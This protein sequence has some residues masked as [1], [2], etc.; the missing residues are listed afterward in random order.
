MLQVLPEVVRAIKLLGLITLAKLVLGSQ[1]VNAC[2]PE[3]R[4]RK[5]LPTVAAK[6]GRIRPVWRLVECRL[7]IPRE[8][9]TRPRVLTQMKRVLMALGLVFVLE[10]VVAVLAAVLL[11]LLVETVGLS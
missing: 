8:R 9:C 7:V 5:F 1:M 10:P 11:F 2:I 6:I 3:C 4:N